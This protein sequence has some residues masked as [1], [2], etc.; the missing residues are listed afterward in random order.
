MVVHRVVSLNA[1]CVQTRGDNNP[2]DD[3]TP[4]PFEA[5]VGRVVAAHRDQRRFSVPGGRQ[6]LAG[7]Y[8][9]KAHRCMR[10]VLAGLFGSAYRG[11]ARTGLGNRLLPV[12][13]RP[14][15]VVFGHSPSQQLK[16]IWGR[17]EIGHY[18]FRAGRWK[19]R[20][21]FRPILNESDLTQAAFQMEVARKRARAMS[22]E[23][24][25]MRAGD[26]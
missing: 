5:I 13:L 12:S 2:S 14:R 7:S 4:V 6:G 18:D 3:P 8:L 10:S 17:R 20:L 11:L 15:M 21:P 24:L 16:L 25:R 26:A 1:A 9:A 19:I 22:L 23:R